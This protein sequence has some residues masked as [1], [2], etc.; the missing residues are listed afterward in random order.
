MKLLGFLLG[1]A[2]GA[3]DHC[4]FLKKKFRAR[5]W[6]L[7]H[8]RRAGIKDLQ[9]YRIYSVLVRPVLE[10]NCVIFH[11]MLTA[12][13]SNSIERLQKQVFRLCFGTR[14]SYGELLHS[15][16]LDTLAARRDKAIKKFVTKALANPRFSGRWF[17]RREE[18]GTEIRRRRPYVEN[19]ARTERYKKS[20]LVY[21]QKIANDLA[22]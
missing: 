7:I 11:P 10:A 8:L 13:Q 5:F 22:A 20:P 17:V 9:L 3:N 1:T 18:V 19:R 2:P 21:M 12:T 6:R 15:L 14:R 16:N 4:D